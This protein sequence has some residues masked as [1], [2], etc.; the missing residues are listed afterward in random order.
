M[1]T[2]Y[3]TKICPFCESEIP[4]TAKKC[5]FCGEW[6]VP[7]P[8]VE[9]NT[10][11]TP[12]TEPLSVPASKPSKPKWILF[13]ELF[14]GLMLIVCLVGGVLYIIYHEGDVNYVEVARGEGPVELQ[15]ARQRLF[16]AYQGG[17]KD[18]YARAVSQMS[19]EE[20]HRRMDAKGLKYEGKASNYSNSQ[21]KNNETDSN[22]R[23]YTF[24][25]DINVRGYLTGGKFVSPEGLVLTFSSSLEMIINGRYQTGAM[26][27][28]DYDDTRAVIQGYSP[29]S[30]GRVRLR[31]NNQNNTI[32]NMDEPDEVFFKK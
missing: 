3:E 5:H 31:V 32:Q 15:D 24:H 25:S 8:D 28:V 30:G 6:V 26:S 18:G 21:R 10:K 16:E 22:S 7:K 12:K 11:E 14:W 23:R 9:E 1:S 29:Y 27:I 2:K 13:G 20:V 19:L 4:A 17:G